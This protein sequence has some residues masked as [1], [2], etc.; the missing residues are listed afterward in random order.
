MT[1]INLK[2]KVCGMRDP[3]NILE[4]AALAPDYM[5]FIFYP[6]S[7]RYVGD[8]FTLPAGIPSS[9]RRVGVF[10]NAGL[11]EIQRNV[12]RASLT[13]VQLH[14][15]ESPELCKALRA[16]GVEVI[17]VFRVDEDTDFKRVV[18]WHGAVDFFLFDTKGQYYGGN[19]RTFRWAVIDRYDQ[20]TPFFL[21]GGITPDHIESIKELDNYNLVAID[22]NSGVEIRPAEKDV[23]K[24][25]LVRERLR[26][27]KTEL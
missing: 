9:V 2:L 4:V 23:E 19:A 27:L 14:G 3:E 21:S 10:V 22:I 25:R 7:P 17:K 18:A 8:D 26:T 13:T 20:Q 11:E 6:P 1:L 15:D 12:Q 16:S 24:I 5:G